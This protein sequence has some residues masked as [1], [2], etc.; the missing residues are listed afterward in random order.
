MTRASKPSAFAP[1]DRL[2]GLSKPPSKDDI[3][4]CNDPRA[5]WH[6]RDPQEFERIWCVNCKNTE[7]VR[8]KGSKMPWVERMQN[9]PDYLINDPIF[10]DLLSHAHRVLAE[11]NF[12]P[13]N[14]QAE[15]LEIADQRQDWSIPNPDEQLRPPPAPVT[16][17]P[18]AFDDPPEPEPEPAPAPAP[19]P[20]PAPR[21][22]PPQPK[23][24]L[25]P[26]AKVAKTNTPM[27]KGGLLVGPAPS[28]PA[29]PW[30][31]TNTG[32]TVLPGATVIL[33]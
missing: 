22:L 33:K 20:P 2:V 4:G 28:P 10:S 25:K 8:S 27:P 14:A 9:Q 3:E 32:T 29:D 24:V 17:D 30:T 13:R 16:S 31:P 23:P 6:Q 5:A 26:P 1:T 21:P 7:C 15:R 19:A 11:Q 18:H 12:A